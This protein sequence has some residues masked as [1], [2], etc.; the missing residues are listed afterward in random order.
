MQKGSIENTTKEQ[1]L[2][3]ILNNIGILLP[4]PVG[5][6][7]FGFLKK[8]YRNQKLTVIPYYEPDKDM[9]S[10]LGATLLNPLYKPKNISAAIIELATK[11]YF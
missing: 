3:G 8:K 6:Y 10:L 9:D 7:L 4:I 11:G 2:L 5:I 1:I